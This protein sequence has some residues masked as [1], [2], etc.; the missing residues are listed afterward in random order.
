MIIIIGDS[1]G[2]G[3]WDRCC[4]LG[5][6]RFGQY[7]ML[8]DQV[9]NLSLGAG[10]NTD[11]LDRLSQFLKKFK[12]DQYDTI[13]WIVTCPSRDIDI[14]Q[15]LPDSESLKQKL[16]DYL[17]QSLD[18]AQKL[19]DHHGVRIN[20]IGGLCDLNVIDISKYEHLDVSV[21]SWGQ[22]LDQQYSI[23]LFYPG[24]WT[25]IGLTIKTQYPHH[26]DDW[27]D[28]ADMVIA[29][30]QSWNKIFHTDGSHPDR[31]GHKILHN[32]LYP[33]WAWKLG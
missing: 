31:T 7:L 11:S 8:H 33:E 20:L 22:L 27:N 14:D 12:A 6:P 4:N 18:T 21:A 19:A 28:I 29:K 25:D 30:N 32:Y 2:V 1:W 23:G 16:I 9:C 17:F 15:C 5:G 13:Y 26:L 24:S 10:S 3:E